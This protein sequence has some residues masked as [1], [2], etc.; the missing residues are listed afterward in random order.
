MRGIT[1][2]ADDGRPVEPGDRLRS[3]N[4]DQSRSPY[5]GLIAQRRDVARTKD[6]RR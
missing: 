2:S 6:G 1:F 5:A 3:D 4:E